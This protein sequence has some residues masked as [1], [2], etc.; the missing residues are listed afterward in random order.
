MIFAICFESERKLKT[1]FFMEN[2]L[3]RALAR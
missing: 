2:V 1:E 3:H